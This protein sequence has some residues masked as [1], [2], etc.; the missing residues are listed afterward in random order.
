MNNSGFTEALGA[1]Y[2]PYFG[3]FS[4]R[5]NGTSNPDLDLL[6]GPAK[7]YVQSITYSATGVQ[8]IVFKE[9]F[10]FPTTVAWFCS[11]SCLAVANAFQ[12]S[13]LSWDPTTRTLVLQQAQNTTGVATASNPANVVRVGFMSNNSSGK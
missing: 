11:T 4:Y 9:G 1:G 12:A 2:A 3:W 10:S 13:V 7:R 8:T 6:D 5:P